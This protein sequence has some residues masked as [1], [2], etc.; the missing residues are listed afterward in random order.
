M[1][2]GAE[3]NPGRDNVWPSSLATKTQPGFGGE[4]KSRGRV[5]VGV[6]IGFSWGG[7]EGGGEKAYNCY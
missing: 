3:E 2:R 5:E 4:V 7:V 6:G 1:R